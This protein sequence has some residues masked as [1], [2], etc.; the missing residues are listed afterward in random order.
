MFAYLRLLAARLYP[1]VEAPG[2]LG[3]SRPLAAQTGRQAG[4]AQGSENTHHLPALIHENR[5]FI[6]YKYTKKY[7]LPKARFQIIKMEN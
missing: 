6:Y 4:E 2:S 1:S 3:R 5:H 7:L